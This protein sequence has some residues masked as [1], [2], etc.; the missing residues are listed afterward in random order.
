MSYIALATTTLSSSAGSVTFSSI[1][2][3]VSGVALRDLVLVA[4]YAPTSAGAEA[5]MKI[6]N[7]TGA[8]YPIVYAGG[9]GASA[10]SAAFPSNTLYNMNQIDTN[11]IGV[12]QF[13]D[14]SATDKHKSILHRVNRPGAYTIMQAGR[15]ASTSAITTMEITPSSG[16]WGSG[17]TFSLYGIAG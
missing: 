16:S 9:D 15:W 8:N 3:S 17:T 4:R 11:S 7:D 10:F 6:N 14:F 13:F 1:P 5:R 12:Y 2:T